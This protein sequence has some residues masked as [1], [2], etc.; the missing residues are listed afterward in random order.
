MQIE[1]EDRKTDYTA[2]V[3]G[4]G[5]STQRTFDQSFNNNN[6]EDSPHPKA[7]GVGGPLGPSWGFLCLYSGFGQADH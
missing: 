1:R 5:Y 4:M 2:V 3:F 7:P 6:E